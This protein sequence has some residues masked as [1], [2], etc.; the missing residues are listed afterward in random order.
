MSQCT[1]DLKSLAMRRL[2]RLWRT[3]Y[4]HRSISSTGRLQCMTVCEGLRNW[5]YV[6]VYTIGNYTGIDSQRTIDRWG[7]CESSMTSPTCSRH[8][9]ILFFQEHKKPYVQY[10]VRS[11]VKA[12]LTDFLRLR[13]RIQPQCVR[14]NSGVH[15]DFLLPISASK[16]KQSNIKAPRDRRSQPRGKYRGAP[17][18]SF[19]LLSHRR[20]AAR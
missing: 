1:V 4:T 12:P 13:A 6:A 18:S 7:W 20:S 8:S 16:R 14:W 10:I 11:L 19:S 3:Y 17:L 15:E 5:R 2:P 9:N